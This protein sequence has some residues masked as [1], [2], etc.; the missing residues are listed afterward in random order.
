MGA[1]QTLGAVGGEEGA[2]NNLLEKGVGV[3]RE[4]IQRGWRFQ[5]VKMKNL[6]EIRDR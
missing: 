5:G 6:R 2:E 1:Q 3:A 4:A